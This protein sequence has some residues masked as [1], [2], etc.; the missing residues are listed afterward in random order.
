MTETPK[1][2]HRLSNVTMDWKVTVIMMPPAYYFR[3]G[4]LPDC[5]TGLQMRQLKNRIR[6]KL[7]VQAGVNV[8]LGYGDETG[9][10]L[11]AISDDDSVEEVV[12]AILQFFF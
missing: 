4:E 7:N 12:Q 10:N 9:L 2:R 11:I 3:P 6:E 8:E 5:H 1:I